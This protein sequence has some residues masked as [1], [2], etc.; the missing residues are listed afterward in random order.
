MLLAEK[1]TGR[2]VS[3]A[4]LV[5]YTSKSVRSDPIP[6][7]VAQLRRNDAKKSKSGIWL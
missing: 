7:K 5:D 4:A 6:F 2:A 1:L 3:L